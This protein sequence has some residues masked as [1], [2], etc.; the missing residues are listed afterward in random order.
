[1]KFNFKKLIA[2]FLSVMA[3]AMMFAGCGSSNQ[4]SAKAD[5]L[6]SIK[7]KG[8]LVV[9]TASGYPPYEFVDTSSSDHHVTGIDMALAKAIAD[10][11][12]VKLKIEDMSFDALLSSLKAGKVD[13]AIAGIN[14]TAERKKTV[15]FS[16]VYLTSHQKLLIRK[17]DAGSLKTL[18]DFK[19]KTIGA[20]KN[21]TQAKLA[22]AEMPDSRLVALDKVPSLV[23]ELTNKKIAGIV[24]ESIVAQQY[25]T[26]NDSLA[27]SDAVFKDDK[28][29]T[30]L[31]INKGNEDLLKI[32]NEV[33]K[34][35]K[36]NGNFKKWIKEYSKLAI[37][38][39]QK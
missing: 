9:G 11:L 27:F 6:K 18:A 31:A 19:G 4:S 21:T 39:A 28:K 33:I 38:N 2:V 5:L 24:V 16:D 29:D 15:D 36:D 30:A 25:L 7:A 3:A 34:E 32:I 22:K 37:S 23:L 10:K 35:N 26:S 14:P 17:E 12:G 8:V 13:L 1:M 20:E